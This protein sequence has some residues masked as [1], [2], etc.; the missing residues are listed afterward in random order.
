M[1]IDAAKREQFVSWVIE[2]LDDLVTGA[3]GEYQDLFVPELVEPMQNAWE[4]A[5]G[6]PHL[7][8]LVSRLDSIIE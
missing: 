4:E 5:E 3:N 2:T 7:V 6:F 1:S 8:D